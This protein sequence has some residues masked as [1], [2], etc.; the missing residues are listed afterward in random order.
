M[1]QDHGRPRVQGAI[2]EYSR[3]QG[4]SDQKQSGKNLQSRVESS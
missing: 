2:S 3:Y 1:Y 4:M